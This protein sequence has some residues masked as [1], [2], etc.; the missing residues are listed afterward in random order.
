M[1]DDQEQVSVKFTHNG[2]I[3]ITA[4]SYLKP[5]NKPNVRKKAEQDRNR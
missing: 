5:A 3:E 4:A 2:V 1:S